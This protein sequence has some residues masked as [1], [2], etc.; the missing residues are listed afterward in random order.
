M[1]PKAA[2]R[3]VADAEAVRPFPA[4]LGIRAVRKSISA[5][6][7]R[8][9]G[10]LPR[11]MAQEL[12]PARETAQV[13]RRAGRRLP[14]GMGRLLR[15]IQEADF[16]AAADFSMDS[17]CGRGC[18]LPATIHPTLIQERTK[19]LRRKRP[20]GKCLPGGNRKWISSFFPFS[21]GSDWEIYNRSIKEKHSDEGCFSFLFFKII[22]LPKKKDSLI[23]F[24]GIY[25][26]VLFS[27]CYTIFGIFVFWSGWDIK[28]PLG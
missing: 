8:K 10:W 17:L 3:E 18:G 23:L 14:R 28:C 19:S 4:L 27:L 21:A 15:Q 25:I 12:A 16:L 1:R 7:A 22:P 13:R 2:A 5:A 6:S 11:R 9:N 20:L 26:A 24:S